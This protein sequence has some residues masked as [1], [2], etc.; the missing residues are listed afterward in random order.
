MT[1]FLNVDSAEDKVAEVVPPKESP[2]KVF[3]KS[4]RSSGDLNK[5]APSNFSPR[6]WSLIIDKKQIDSHFNCKMSKFKMAV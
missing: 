6:A 1:R 5:A 2:T 4:F 3:V